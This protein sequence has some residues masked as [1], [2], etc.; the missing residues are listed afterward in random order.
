M[1]GIQNKRSGLVWSGL[2]LILFFG[3]MGYAADDLEDLITKLDERKQMYDQG[4]VSW[5]E[6]V[7]QAQN[8]YRQMVDQFLI[9]SP[10]EG[11]IKDSSDYAILLTQIEHKVWF[12]PT[13]CRERKDYTWFQVVAL[14]QGGTS[15]WAPANQ[16]QDIKR[17]QFVE[18]VQA[19]N[20]IKS[21]DNLRE[22]ILLIF[23]ADPDIPI[24]AVLLDYDKSLHNW[25]DVLEKEP[26]ND[27]KI[28]VRSDNDMV[29]LCFI[30]GNGAW[31]VIHRFDP[32]K[33]YAP[34]SLKSIREKATE[35]EILYTDLQ[36]VK[37]TL[38]VPFK[39][40]EIKFNAGQDLPRELVL[41]Q[42]GSWKMG[43]IEESNL[44]I[45]PSLYDT[46]EDNITGNKYPATNGQ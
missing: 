29:D 46:I 3:Q 15:E 27:Q 9:E 28:E 32:A 19:D 39:K 40:V 36:E 38:F 33:N 31:E 18:I 34:V 4:Q 22:R 13:I 44:K 24:N 35:F 11:T 7:Y 26:L 17:L 6:K 37:P 14:G 2:V 12:T 21:L 25:R 16:L 41:S 10:S 1:R 30:R 45:D 23:A 42:V 5:T 8:G 20:I 43:E